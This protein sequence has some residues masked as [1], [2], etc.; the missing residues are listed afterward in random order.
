M[1]NHMDSN[2]NHDADGYYF[3][4]MCNDFDIISQG[5]HM[6]L[7]FVRKYYTPLDGCMDTYMHV[8]I[9]TYIIILRVWIGWVWIRS[10]S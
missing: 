2:Y 7:T 9:Y 10:E 8:S 5:L 4:I 1:M 3:V 6:I